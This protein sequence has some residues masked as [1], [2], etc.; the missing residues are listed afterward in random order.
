MPY[1]GTVWEVLYSSPV[2]NTKTIQPNILGYSD[3]NFG[4]NLV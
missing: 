1:P 2:L 3:D 4:T